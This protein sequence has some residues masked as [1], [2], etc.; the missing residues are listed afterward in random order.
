VNGTTWVGIDDAL[1]AID[2]LG[3]LA[4][5]EVQ[6]AALTAVGKPIAEDIRQRLEAHHITGETAGDIAVGESKEAAAAGE[7]VVLI[8][9]K[10]RAYLLRWLEFGTFKQRAT[11]VI[12]PAWDSARGGYAAKVLEQYRKAYKRIIAKYSRKKAA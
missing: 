6:I 1:E 12:R 3:E 8:G 4:S 10:D 11:P 7:A 9:A 2:G 5:H